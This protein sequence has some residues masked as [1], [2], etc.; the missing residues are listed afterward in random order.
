ML[1]TLTLNRECVA[2]C[3]AVGDVKESVLYWLGKP[4]IGNQ[5]NRI[6]AATIAAHLKE[7][8]AWD[9]EELADEAENKRRLLWTA[10]CSAQEAIH[11]KQS[12]PCTTYVEG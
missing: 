6:P 10:A 4:R 11:T 12:A 9:A 8:G 1:Y 5:I 2:D 3:S 7:F